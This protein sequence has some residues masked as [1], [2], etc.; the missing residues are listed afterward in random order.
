MLGTI[1]PTREGLAKSDS[2]FDDKM[3]EA[4]RKARKECS[5]LYERCEQ[6]EVRFYSDPTH[7]RNVRGNWFEIRK[8][9]HY[10][11]KLG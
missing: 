9:G 1:L 10:A 6:G 4:L 5:G 11:A 8:D 7:Y 3:A 2:F